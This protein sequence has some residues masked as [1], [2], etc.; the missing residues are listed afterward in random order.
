MKKTIYAAA[1]LSFLVLF[2]AVSAIE[3]GGALWIALLAV[4]AA[5]TFCV[6]AAKLEKIFIKEGEQQ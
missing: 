5:L 1:A 2:C 4:P 3:N 6:C